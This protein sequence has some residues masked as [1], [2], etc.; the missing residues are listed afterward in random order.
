MALFMQGLWAE[1]QPES[2]YLNWM[3]QTVAMNPS[4]GF[5]AMLP[6]PLNVCWGAWTA[7]GMVGRG[8]GYCL[9]P[10]RSAA[11]EEDV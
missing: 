6:H 4:M 1:M 8:L 9:N 11:T 5:F 2:A 3:R 7:L 10:N